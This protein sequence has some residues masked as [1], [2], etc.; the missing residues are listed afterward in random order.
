M[1]KSFFMIECLSES[2]EYYSVDIDLN[3]TLHFN[4]EIESGGFLFVQMS[5]AS[6][7]YVNFKTKVL[8]LHC[9]IP[10]L[11]KRNWT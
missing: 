10:F 3:I 2:T 4:R 8:R 9:D 7:Y 6:R 1:R 5:P 11:L